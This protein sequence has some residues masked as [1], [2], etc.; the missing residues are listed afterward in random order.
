MKLDLGKLLFPSLPRDIRRRKMFSV[1]LT[2]VVCVAAGLVI[3]VW[4]NKNSNTHSS[5]GSPFN[6]SQ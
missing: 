2:L 1:Y 5:N 6:I 3:V 4:M